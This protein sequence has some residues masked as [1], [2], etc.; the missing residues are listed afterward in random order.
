[1]NGDEFIPTLTHA[2]E[3]DIDLILVEEFQASADFVVWML[4]QVGITGPIAKW[5]VKHSKRRTRSRREID[6]FT[7]IDLADGTRAAVLIEN[8]LDATEQPD[9]AESYQEELRLLSE[10]Y[11]FQ[12]M[13]IVCPSAYISAHSEFISKFDASITYE[14]IEQYFREAEREAGTEAVLRFRF[15]AELMDQAVNKHRRG[16]TPIPDE[17]VGD[18]NAQYVYL[19]AEIAPE[20]KPGNSM[21]KPANPRES[22]SMIF[23]Q[24]A[25]LAELPEEI[26]PRRFA[27]ELGRGSDRRANYVAATFAGWGKAFP[28]LREQLEADTK[29]LGAKFSAKPATK[30]R[31]N[32][33]LVVSIPSEPVDNQSS[34]E[35]QRTKLESGIRRAQDLR[36]WLLENQETLHAWKQRIEEISN[37]RGAT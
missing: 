2:T 36:R 33:G 8:K 6:I 21:L 19:L 1:M 4:A 5:D 20:I 27:H 26:R 7:E 13:I 29:S 34:F 3:R 18:F 17:I 9:Q 22:T 25:S 35:A 10:G 28:E 16:Y 15:R 12:A 23:D 11:D 31:P 24:N 14:G 32:P 30:V 37:V